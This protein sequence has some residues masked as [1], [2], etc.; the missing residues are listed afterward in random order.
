MTTRRLLLLTCPVIVALLAPFWIATAAM[1]DTSKAFDVETRLQA[2]SRKY[3]I[4]VEVAK[5]RISVPRAFAEVYHGWKPSRK[6]LEY[7]VPILE[8][9]WNLYPVSLIRNAG[10]QRIVLCSELAFEADIRAAIPD[11]QDNT[12][13]L[14]V[15]FVLSGELYVRR[16]IHHEFF[17]MID[18][19]D[20]GSFSDKSWRLLNGNDFVYRGRGVHSR[21]ESAITAKRPGF[22]TR[23]SMTEV[24]EDKAEVF[25]IMIVLGEVVDARAEKD[26][27]IRAKRD[28]MKKL[29]REFCPDI[30][31]R[32]WAAAR[33]L[34]RPKE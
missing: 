15:D 34:S 14:D 17:H 3:S 20:D 28:Q 33:K 7:Y 27:V 2:L 18:L 25:S 4:I 22:L 24:E 26:S 19:A 1:A 29:L 10:L 30:D 5:D 13:Y 12:L 11:F 6:T 8:A 16:V 23:Y 32:F 31:D 21:N 9:E